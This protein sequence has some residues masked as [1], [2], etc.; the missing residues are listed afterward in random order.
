MSVA[1]RAV[2]LA[3][4]M[5]MTMMPMIVARVVS[6]FLLCVLGHDSLSYHFR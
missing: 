5:T 1:R 3:M 4:T 2:T 6:V